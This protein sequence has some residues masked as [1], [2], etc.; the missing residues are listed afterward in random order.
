MFAILFLNFILPCFSL[1]CTTSPIFL[2]LLLW[3]HVVFFLFKIPTCSWQL[4]FAK[5][6]IG[7]KWKHSGLIRAR[8]CFYTSCYVLTA[9]FLLLIPLHGLCLHC[10]SSSL[11]HLFS[12]EFWSA[13]LNPLLVQLTYPLLFS[14]LVAVMGFYWHKDL[15]ELDM[16]LSESYVP[17]SLPSSEKVGKQELQASPFAII[18]P[19]DLFPSQLVLLNFSLIGPIWLDHTD[20]SVLET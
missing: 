12:L 17:G 4:T 18:P 14:C 7:A 1:S 9:F 2:L 19:K 11:L 15:K 10:L 20:H 3:F 5:T 16:Q 8:L 13:A 6:L